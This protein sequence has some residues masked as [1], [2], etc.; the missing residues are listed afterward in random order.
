MIF[1]K[2]SKDQIVGFDVSKK[3]CEEVSKEYGIKTINN[4]NRAI[5]EFNPEVFIISTP[6]NLHHQYF[7][8]AARHKKH[9][10]VEVPTT[11]QGYKKLISYLDGSFVAAPSCTFCYVPGVKKSKS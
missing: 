10:F 8:Y 4:F 7:L 2:I 9:F 6:P 3:R 1:H 5:K 11:D